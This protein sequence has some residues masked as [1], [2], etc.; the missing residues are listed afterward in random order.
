MSSLKSPVRSPLSR[1]V[2]SAL[3][4]DGSSGGAAANPL[5]FASAF[6]RRNLST[7]TAT[8]T[9]TKMWVRYKVILGTDDWGDLR[10][11]FSGTV[12][13]G[14]D[15]PVGNDIQIEKCALEKET[16][17]AAHTPVYFSGLRTATVTNG[18]AKL[19]SDP[20]LPSAFSLSQFPK[21][22]VYWVRVLMSAAPS[23]N[24]PST[25]WSQKTGAITLLFN[26]VTCGVSDIDG[27]GT[28]SY[29]VGT[30]GTGPTDFSFPN[31][32]CPLVIG[33]PKTSAGKYIAGVGD[34]I[35]FD[36]DDVTTPPGSGWITG[37]FT[38]SLFDADFASNPRAGC[39]FG[40]SGTTASLWNTATVSKDLLQYANV[41]VEEFG[42]NGAQYANSAS[43]WAAAKVWLHQV[44]RTK[45]LT[46]TTGSWGSVG[47]QTKV[48]AWTSPSGDRIVFNDQIAAQEG[49]LYDEFVDFDADA[50]YA[51]DRDYWDPNK[52][53]D[54]THPNS[55]THELM[56][57]R[58]RSTYAALP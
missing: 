50:L 26:P 58:M 6:N 49:I 10:I 47:A 40:Y 25:L 39:N 33:T 12:L 54:G 16:G 9:R 22:G 13:G 38:R 35:V 4:P 7:V 11:V 18:L 2:L 5:R 51:I 29:G 52:T 32:F 43:I 27:T 1:A 56:A 3:V 23:A 28:P 34:S 37:F 42:T 31:T 15:A 24:Y 21:A 55:A 57:A 8:A 17:G 44:I 14:N 46:V 45:L 53:A 48:A 30:G 41:T 20:I 19:I 36:R